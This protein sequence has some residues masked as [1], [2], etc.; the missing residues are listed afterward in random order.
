MPLLPLL[1][2]QIHRLLSVL[3]L[4][5][6]QVLQEQLLLW[7]LNLLLKAWIARRKALLLQ[8]KVQPRV[9]LLLMLLLLLQP[10]LWLT[11]RWTGH[12]EQLLLLLLLLGLR[13]PTLVRVVL[14]VLQRSAGTFLWAE[15]KV[16]GFGGSPWRARCLPERAAGTPVAAQPSAK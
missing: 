9:G 4:L 1:L 14:P 3:L 12:A 10:Q 6:Q 15:L 13:L 7:I 5:S 2:P 8:D 16:A 11:R